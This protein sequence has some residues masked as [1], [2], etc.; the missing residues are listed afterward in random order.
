[1]INLVAPKL[2]RQASAALLKRSAMRARRQ[3][4]IPIDRKG[5]LIG[6]GGE[7]IN[8]TTAY[9]NVFAHP[10]FCNLHKN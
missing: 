8:R 1:M 4:T 10:P 5:G 7:G 9:I 6:K 3:I 2:P